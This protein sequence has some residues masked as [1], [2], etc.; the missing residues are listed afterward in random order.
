MDVAPLERLEQYIK[1]I[2]APFA[3]WSRMSSRSRFVCSV[4]VCEWLCVLQV[5][6]SRS[7]K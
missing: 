3:H 1:A 6:K 7:A 2:G 4:R 5:V